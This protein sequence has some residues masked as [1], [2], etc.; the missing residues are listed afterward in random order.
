MRTLASVASSCN[1][2]FLAQKERDEGEKGAEEEE[3]RHTHTNLYTKH[4]PIHSQVP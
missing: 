2:S 1:I 3:R 4:A